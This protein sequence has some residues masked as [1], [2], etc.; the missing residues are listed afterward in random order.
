MPNKRY[1]RGS[2]S[3]DFAKKR[4]TTNRKE[5]QGVQNVDIN[6]KKYG[7]GCK[8]MDKKRQDVEHVETQGL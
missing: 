1:A 7:V 3:T 5:G 6:Q 2:S 8:R 4:K